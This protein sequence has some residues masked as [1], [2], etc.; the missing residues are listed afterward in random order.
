MR[1]KGFNVVDFYELY[2]SSLFVQQVDLRHHHLCPAAFLAILFH[3]GPELCTCTEMG[4][5]WKSTSFWSCHRQSV[6][7]CRN[8][9]RREYLSPWPGTHSLAKAAYN[10]F[11][12]SRGA[13]EARWQWQPARKRS[14]GKIYCQ[15]PHPRPHLLSKIRTFSNFDGCYVGC[16]PSIRFHSWIA[17]PL[18]DKQ[19][20]KL[21]SSFPIITSGA[22][23]SILI[24]A[25]YL[26]DFYLAVLSSWVTN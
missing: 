8:Q 18:I 14:F 2:E 16:P 25:S 15:L 6:G 12:L 20:S 19:H 5:V 22:E 17:I 10:L 26:T 21:K 7:G 24:I 4:V 13:P 1:R 23:P 9:T 3:L 11:S